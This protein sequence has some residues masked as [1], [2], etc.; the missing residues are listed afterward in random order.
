MTTLTANQLASNL[1]LTGKTIVL[2]VETDAV[3][4]YP[5]R[6]DFP[7]LGRLK[8]LYVAEDTGVLWAWTGTT[9]SK[10]SP[11]V[12]EHASLATNLDAE[13]LARAQA[14]DAV[15][16]AI[17]AE[18]TNR[19][20]ALLEERDSR[21]AALSTL[22]ADLSEETTRALAAEELLDVK[23]DEE[24]VA[25]SIDF[26]NLTQ[27]LETIVAVYPTQADFPATG[28]LRRLYLDDSLGTL[29]RW[30]GTIYQPAPGEM[31]GGQY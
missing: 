12:S 8:R 16:L 14:I 29:W 18:A 4:H 9:Y 25:R 22:S 10:T 5:S 27:E 3:V 23:I 1:D 30:T 15:N 11:T 17:S 28:R 21:E 20:L 19:D 7:T 13:S 31:D 2:P 26:G 6:S 24:I